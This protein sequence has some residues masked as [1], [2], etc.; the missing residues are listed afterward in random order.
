MPRNPAA[1]RLVIAV[2]SLA[3]LRLGESAGDRIGAVHEIDHSICGR[4]QIGSGYL[5]LMAGATHRCTAQND[6]EFLL[7]LTTHKRLQ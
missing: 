4:Q 3:W 5:S 6:A 1:R 2:S 7:A